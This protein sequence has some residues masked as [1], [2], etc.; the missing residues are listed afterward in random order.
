[1]TITPSF[2]NSTTIGEIADVTITMLE[3]R[4]S[5]GIV[6]EGL[7]ANKGKVYG[8]YNVANQSVELYILDPFTG[9]KF[10]KV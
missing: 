4:P 9:N 2:I 1:M 6:F 7:E 8:Y 3:E 10:L 5:L